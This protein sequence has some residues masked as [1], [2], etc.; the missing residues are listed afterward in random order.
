MTA[1]FSGFLL[2]SQSYRCVGTGTNFV[3]KVTNEESK[4]SVFV[5][6]HVPN[7]SGEIFESDLIR[8]FEELLRYGLEGMEHKD[9]RDYY[10]RG[11]F[12]S[13][14]AAKK[15]WEKCL[16]AQKRLEQLGMDWDQA[17]AMWEPIKEFH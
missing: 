9:L 7:M 2:E 12:A 13:E 17:E 3:V 1:S 10:G 4:V 14:E 5:M 15:E 6:T 16:L 8:C 11:Y